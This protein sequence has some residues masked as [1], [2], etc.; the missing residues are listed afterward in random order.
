MKLLRSPLFVSLLASA[1]LA[2]AQSSTVCPTGAVFL[3]ITDYNSY[4]SQVRGYPTRANGPTLPCQVLRGP[5]TTLSTTNGVSVSI[6]GNLHVMQFLTN[7][8]VAVFPPNASG[9]IAPQRIESTYTNDLLAIAT[10]AKVTDFVLTRREGPAAIAVLLA[11]STTPANGIN[12]P[13]FQQAGSLAVDGENNLVVGGYDFDNK[14]LV[15]TLGTNRSYSAPVVVRTL[16]GPNTGLFMGDPQDFSTNDISLAVD[17]E[18]GELYV[19]GYSSA[20]KKA[21]IGVFPAKAAGDV[22]PS[23]VISGGLTQIGPPGEL[24]NKIAVSADG[25]LF[26]AEANDRIL[27]F[28]PGAS[29]NVPPAQI[30]QDSTIGTGSV[31]QGG[32]GV[33]SCQC[34]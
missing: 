1:G 4:V 5:Q 16:S 34:H 3:A 27:V 29:G 22:R 21:Q 18:S 20:T 6:H 13:G 14:G 28:A 15:E 10:D 32:I 30:I 26:V 19:Y 31:A 25:R 7:G 12:A 24:N 17:A 2:A 8:T 23:R 33:R 9:N 11:G